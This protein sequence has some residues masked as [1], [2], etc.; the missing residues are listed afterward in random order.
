MEAAP[1]RDG[2]VR[3]GP[4][5]VMHL[6]GGDVTAL[7]PGLARSVGIVRT[8][9]ERRAYVYWQGQCYGK[10]PTETIGVRNECLRQI[11]SWKPIKGPEYLSRF[12]YRCN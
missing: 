10:L 4:T 8:S 7:A 1:G 2:D 11:G 6:G 5:I 9:P 12:A 3:F